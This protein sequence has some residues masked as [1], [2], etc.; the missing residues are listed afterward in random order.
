MFITVHILSSFVPRGTETGRLFERVTMF[1]M[2]DWTSATVGIFHQ[3]I[4]GNELTR[5][6]KLLSVIVW[7][8]YKVQ[9]RCKSHI[10]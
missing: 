2:S 5:E 1:F 9:R 3:G 10:C 6:K 8:S 4:E 7:P